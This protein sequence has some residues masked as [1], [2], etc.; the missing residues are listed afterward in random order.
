MINLAKILKHNV[1]GKLLNH[2]IVFCI[3]IFLV[4]FLGPAFSGPYFNELYVLNFIVFIFSAGLDYAAIALV[5]RNPELLPAIHRMLFK[6]VL[7]FSVIVLFYVFVLLPHTDNYFKQPSLAIVFFSIGNLLLIF[8]QGILSAMK[9]FNQQNFILCITNLLFL[10]YLF[11]FTKEDASIT[12]TKLYHIEIIYASVF[13]LQGL[14][15][16]GSSFKTVAEKNITV[17]WNKVIRAG[18]F[19]MLSSLIYFAFLRIDNFFVQKYT[20]ATTLSNYVQCGKIGQYFLY[21]SSIVSSTLLPFISSETVGSSFPEWKKMMKPY[22][23]LL[24]LAALFIAITGKT[25]FPLLF[26]TEFNNM[27]SFILILLPGFICLGI[28]TLINAVYIGKGNIRA[29]L[30]GD[31][32]GLVIV[33]GFDAWLVPLYGAYAAAAISSVTYCL[34]FLFLLK[35]FKQQFSQ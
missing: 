1:I 21:F 11:V 9:K 13:L 7:L 5:S 29:I 16:W 10:I 26:G 20:D 22:I 34:V 19:I 35:N 6:V 2:I 30:A 31:I 25:I 15:M 24:C 32:L 33:T 3:N 4:R 17:S 18:I 14:L 28:L 23:S 8:Y 12:T 27:Y